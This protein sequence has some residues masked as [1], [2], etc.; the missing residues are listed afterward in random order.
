MELK[1]YR[2]WNDVPENLKTK[3]QLKEMKL[4]P[5]GKPK[6]VKLGHQAKE[7]NLYDIKETESTKKIKVDIAKID[8]NINNIAEALY[9]I[10]KS[11]KK[12]RD[13]KTQNYDAG[14]FDVV[15]RAKTRQLKLYGLKNAVI[16]KLL[17]DNKAE[18]IGYHTQK[19]NYLLLIRINDYTFHLPTNEQRVKSLKCLGEIGIISAETTRKTALKFN[20][21][22]KLLEM[23]V[24]K[25]M[26]EIY[27][28]IFISL[29]K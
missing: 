29:L 21:A 4:K 18:I 26:K 5:I 16:D 8:L 17:N 7:Y 22:V 13:T 10:N 1:K 6:A 20:E 15:S 24:G 12:S 11:V 28:D 9:I 23:Y 19:D 2:H 3:T 27:N 14:R 25:T